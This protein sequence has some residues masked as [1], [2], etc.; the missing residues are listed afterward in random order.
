MG[1]PNA[2]SSDDIDQVRGI[3]EGLFQ[4]DA[5]REVAV[6]GHSYGGTLLGATLSGL[7]KSERQAAGQ[8][9]GVVG[10]IYASCLILKPEDKGKNFSSVQAEY[11]PEKWYAPAD[12]AA[13]NITMVNSQ[14]FASRLLLSGALTDHHKWHCLVL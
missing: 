7:S 10:A 6:V 2:T 11:S 1:N 4:E 12:Y 8:Q 9:G 13:T 14:P 3:I 5:T